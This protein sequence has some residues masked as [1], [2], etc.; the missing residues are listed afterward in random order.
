M[1]YWPPPI[2]LMLHQTTVLPILLWCFQQVLNTVRHDLFCLW[3]VNSAA[4]QAAQQVKRRRYVLQHILC[5]LRPDPSQKFSLY[6]MRLSVPVTVK[7]VRLVLLTATPLYSS[8]VCLCSRFPCPRY[9][10]PGYWSRLSW[11]CNRKSCIDAVINQQ[12]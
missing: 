7:S 4:Q 9:T 5:K 8:Q 2:F 11:D 12:N 10:S 1:F 6:C 3:E